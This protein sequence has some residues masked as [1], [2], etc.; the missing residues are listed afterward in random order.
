MAGISTTA[1][2][3]NEL[4]NNSYFLN[5]AYSLKDEK[6]K[7]YLKISISPYISRTDTVF[8]FSGIT[9]GIM[10]GRVF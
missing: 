8:N 4:A 10:I 3:T 7:L 2:F 6:S 9:G 5:I 1:I